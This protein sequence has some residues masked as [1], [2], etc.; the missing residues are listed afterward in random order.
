MHNQL[1]LTVTP[2]QDATV[3][4]LGFAARSDYVEWFWLPVLGPSATWLL[5]RIDFGFDEFPAGYTLDVRAT[6]QALGVAARDDAGSIFGRAITR[7]NTF[8]IAHG[9]SG[10]FAIRRVLPPV[11]QRHLARMPEHLRSAHQAWIR[12]RDVVDCVA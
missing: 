9:S 2:W 10:T 6:A 3:E 8:G 4:S 5:R 1:T 7:L 12:Q 11:S